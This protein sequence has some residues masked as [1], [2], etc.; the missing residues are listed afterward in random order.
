MFP[1]VFS[2]ASLLFCGFFFIYFHRYIRR[3]TSHESILADCEDAVARLEAQ[4]DAITD[5]DARLV[6]ERIKNLKKLLE[7]VDRR[8][9]LLSRIEDRRKPSEALYDFSG[10]PIP[11]PGP[12]FPAPPNAGD[13]AGTDP[14]ASS[15]A[16][17]AAQPAPEYGEDTRS[18][19]DRAAE[20]DRAGLSPKLIASRLGVSV[21]EAE[22]A[23]TVS[24]HTRPGG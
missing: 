17:P 18:L 7:N 8:I 6:E 22:L 5:R 16:L 9:S 23:V 12:A 21:S 19:V 2:T 10:N 13:K 11:F 24:R 4:I 14:E 15:T 20:L 1:L 3:R